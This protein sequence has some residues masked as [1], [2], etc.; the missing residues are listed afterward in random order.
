MEPPYEIEGVTERLNAQDVLHAMTPEQKDAYRKNP[1]ERVRTVGNLL[2]S[3][4]EHLA[5]EGKDPK[6]VA[7]ELGYRLVDRENPPTAEEIAAFAREL[8]S[9]HEMTVSLNELSGADRFLVLGSKWKDK[10]GLGDVILTDNM[11]NHWQ[12]RLNDVKSHMDRLYPDGRYPDS[13][14]YTINLSEFNEHDYEKVP[15][16]NS[17]VLAH[18][19]ADV[20][21]AG[22]KQSAD[23]ARALL[24]NIR[25]TVA[26]DERKAVM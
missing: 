4:Y 1:S 24:Y 26:T 7:Q 25:H 21:Q 23:R 10:F 5:Q 17:L 16:S 6:T 15:V 19:N 8:R 2:G 12:D 22:F 18:S 9:F 11:V 20:F 13:V 14:K 3:D